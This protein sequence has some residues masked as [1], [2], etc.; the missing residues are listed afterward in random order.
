MITE[1][2]GKSGFGLIDVLC[3]VFLFHLVSVSVGIR[4]IHM[5]FPCLQFPTP[6]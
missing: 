5:Y 4:G 1:N 6:R 3:I 2:H